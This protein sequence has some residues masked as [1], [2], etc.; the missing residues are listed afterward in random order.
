M[1][2]ANINACVSW[3]I[4]S[5]LIKKKIMLLLWLSNCV[6]L[7]VLGRLETMA[8][9]PTLTWPSPI[10]PSASTNYLG[11][12]FINN[13]RRRHFY[14]TKWERESRGKDGRKY[15]MYLWR[16]LSVR[17]NET[18]MDPGKCRLIFYIFIKNIRIS[19][20]FLDIF[21]FWKRLRLEGGW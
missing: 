19:P 3:Y 7:V 11:I 9:S 8:E 5:F 15:F 13:N 16:N 14:S 18:F 21:F 20:P 1:V 17:R 2:S 10:D 12:F 4:L 6:A